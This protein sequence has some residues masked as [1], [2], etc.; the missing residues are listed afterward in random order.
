MSFFLESFGFLWFPLVWGWVDSMVFLWFPL[1]SFDPAKMSLTL[2][3]CQT[4]P[5]MVK[6]QHSKGETKEH[7]IRGKDKPIKES[8]RRL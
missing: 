6:L 2:S 5:T 8:L 4:G 3:E 7:T 1:A